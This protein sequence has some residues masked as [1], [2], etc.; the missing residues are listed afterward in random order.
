M[1]VVCEFRGRNARKK[2]FTLIELLVVI[3]IIAILA[4]LLLPALARAKQEAQKA[5]CLSDLKQLQVCYHMY[6]GDYNDMLPPNATTSDGMSST[7]NSWVTGDA[8]IT[9]TITDITNG[10]LFPYNKSVAIYRCP[11]DN[12]LIAPGAHDPPGPPVPIVRDCSISGVLGGANIEEY[13]PILKY[14][15]IINPGPAQAIVFVD[16]NENS[17][18]NGSFLIDSFGHSWPNLP[19]SRHEKGCTFSFADGH[20]DYWKWRGTAVLTFVDYG[21]SVPNNSADMADLQRIQNA[22]APWAH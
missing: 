2:A 16:E 10:M 4:S 17:V 12:K 6:V 21:Q 22:A 14:S 8:Q 7:S 3:A 11:S 18:D 15:D 1:K 9:T 5:N 20:V 19:G 13:P